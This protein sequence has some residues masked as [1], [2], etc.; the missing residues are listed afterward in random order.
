MPRNQGSQRSGAK[1]V[2]STRNAAR[3]FGG[4]IDFGVP[5]SRANTEYGRRK[6][7]EAKFN[8]S[9]SHPSDPRQEMGSTQQARVS[10]VGKANAGPGGA[11]SGDI[12]SDIVGV[13]SGSGLAQSGPDP[14][15]VSGPEWSTG[16]SDEFASGPPAR[17]ENQSRRGRTG[18]SKRVPGSSVDRT[19]GDSD[20]TGQD[21]I[22][23]NSRSDQRS[24]ASGQK[25]RRRH[26]RAT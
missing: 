14:S 22:G 7:R 6:S 13:G 1:K 24:T 2:G 8:P 23:V 25:Q 16:T 19:G 11:S 21:T 5:G 18:G 10:G 4:N 9:T 3:K 12:D 26:R 20:T 17:G 15:G